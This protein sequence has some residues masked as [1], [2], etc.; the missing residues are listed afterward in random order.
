MITQVGPT[1]IL[2]YRLHYE[3]PPPKDKHGGRHSKT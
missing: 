3:N 2:R 1:F